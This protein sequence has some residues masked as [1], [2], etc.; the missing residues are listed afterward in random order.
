M[1]L[2]NIIIM[3]LLKEIDLILIMNQWHIKIG[4]KHTYSINV[5]NYIVHCI[6]KLLIQYL[7]PTPSPIRNSAILVFSTS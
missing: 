6:G 1:F 7:I 5:S 2:Y 3:L 4:K